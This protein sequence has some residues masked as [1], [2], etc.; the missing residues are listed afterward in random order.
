MQPDV[1]TQQ[2]H[3]P[4]ADISLFIRREDLIHPFISGNKYRK[5]KYNLVA[6]QASG[7]QTLLTFG[8]AFSNHIAAVAYAGKENGFHTIGIIRGEEIAEKI[9]ENPT[10]SFAVE[11]GMQLEFISREQYRLKDSGQLDNF[12]KE[13]YGNFY[14]IKNPFFTPNFFLP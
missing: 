6:A 12:L 5:L 1:I 10:L 4:E 8:G 11:C 2:I 13:K 14:Q 3:I 7:K 9:T